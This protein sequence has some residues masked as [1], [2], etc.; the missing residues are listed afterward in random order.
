MVNCAQC[1]DM[2]PDARKHFSLD[3]QCERGI[4]IH[5]LIVSDL[6]FYGCQG[7]LLVGGKCNYTSCEE[8]LSAGPQYLP[9]PGE[10]PPEPTPPQ[11][12]AEVAVEETG[13]NSPPPTQ[14]PTM[15]P[16]SRMEVGATTQTKNNTRPFLDLDPPGE[17]MCIVEK[18]NR[19]PF[20]D[21]HLLK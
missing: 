4:Y 14:P 10:L 6:C 18:Q 13:E 2:F 1:T 7:T 19:T 21:V 16:S 17:S 20:A 9:L 8:P 5:I 12:P 15:P 3:D 11:E